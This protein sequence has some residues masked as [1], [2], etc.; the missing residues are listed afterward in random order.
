MR[1]LWDFR[2]FSYGYAKRGIGVFTQCLAESIIMNN[3]THIIYVWADKESLPKAI[4]NWPVKWIPYKRSSWKWSLLVIPL[5]IIKYRIHIMHYWV[6]LGPIHTIG[7]GIIHPCK[8]IAMVYDLGVELWKDI[9]FARSKRKTWYWKVQKHL[10]QQSDYCI[11]ISQ[12]TERN[13]RTVLRKV[14]FPREIIYVPMI[15]FNPPNNNYR[16]P[17][18]ITL[19]GSIHKNIS[20]IIKAFGNLTNDFPALRLVVLGE[21]DRALELPATLPPAVSFE[22][23]VRYKYHLQYASGLILCSFYEG[24]GIPAIE[25]MNYNCPVL[26]SD[27]PSLREIC[28][29][30]AL[31][32]NPKK[33]TEIAQAMK[34]II[35]HQ[36]YWIKKSAGGRIYYESIS[37]DAG[38]RVLKLYDQI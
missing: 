11:C 22:S 9:P 20:R 27:I 37:K 13:L 16:E 28:N 31:F 29:D 25:A 38:K 6:T 7:M 33:I 19:G 2:L 34:E 15:K 18:F 17:Y 10:I 36:Q 23:M 21:I 26:L 4:R 35:L 30:S 14:S 12:A 3:G 5:L 8:V 1:I 32:V 24:L